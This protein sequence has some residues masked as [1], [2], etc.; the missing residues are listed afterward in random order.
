[1]LRT[2]KSW[3]KRHWKKLAVASAASAVLY[4]YIKKSSRD[5]DDIIISSS[6]SSAIELCAVSPT[7]L[8]GSI[9]LNRR[10]LLGRGH[11]RAAY[12][13]RPPDYRLRASSREGSNC[14]VFTM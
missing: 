11:F 14:Q 4:Y 6:L 1:M 13:R 2:I 7:V 10:A 3:V 12:P 8:G 5:Q 9:V